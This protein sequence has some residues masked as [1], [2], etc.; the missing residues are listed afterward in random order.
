MDGL[1]KA[2]REAKGE[3]LPT[4]IEIPV[5]NDWPST[6]RFKALPKVRGVKD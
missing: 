2:I 3:E 1:R 6:N 5:G 4:V